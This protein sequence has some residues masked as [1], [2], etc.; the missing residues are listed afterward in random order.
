MRTPVAAKIALVIA[1]VAG[2][3]EGSPKTRRRVVGLEE[4]HVDRRRH[5]RHARRL[6]LIE[7]VLHDPTFVDGDFPRHQVT[8]AF[9]EAALHEAGRTGCGLTI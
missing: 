7:I 2:G 5:L 8:H 9:D 1:G 6:I 3:S 4:L